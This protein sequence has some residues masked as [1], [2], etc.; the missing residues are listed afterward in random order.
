MDGVENDKVRNPLTIR[1]KGKP[2]SKTKMS[3]VE[4]VVVKKSQRRTNQSND[5]NPKQK[6]RQNRVMI[7]SLVFIYAY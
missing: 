2:L 7:L 6:R 4:K 5:T 1:G 3:L